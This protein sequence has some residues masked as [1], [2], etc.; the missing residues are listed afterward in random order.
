RLRYLLGE[1]FELKG[2][3]EAYNSFPAIA[4]HVTAYARL[5]LWE[6]MQA[7]G[8][9][10]YVYCDTDSL[11]VT[12]VGLD[13]LTPYLSPTELGKLKLEKTV[14]HLI[15]RGL[16]DYSA[17]EKIVIKGVRKSATQISDGVYRQEQWPSFKGIFKSTDANRYVVK[18]VTKHLTREYTKGDVGDNG[19][20]TPFV[21]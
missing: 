18:H 3:S 19:V 4:S 6:L 5:Y 13:N 1:L 12:D 8:H 21:L 2:H 14:D 17:D 11:M 20:I 15:I 7:C 10:N 16:K 9:G